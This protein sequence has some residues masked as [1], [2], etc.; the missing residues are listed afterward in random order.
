M[1]EPMK[2][3]RILVEGKGENAVFSHSDVQPFSTVLSEAFYFS[4]IK[5]S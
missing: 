5:N 2:E 4:V 1:L 3:Q